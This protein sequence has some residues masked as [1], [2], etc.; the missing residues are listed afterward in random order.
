MAKEYILCVDDEP[1]VL[2][3]LKQ[4]IKANPF[5]AD[6]SVIILDSPQKAEGVVREILD[7]RGLIP[8]VISDQRMP[9]IT[10]DQLLISLH[11]VIPTARKILLTGYSDLD[12][13]VRLVN[14]NCLYRYISKPW[15]REDLTLT[16]RNAIGSWRQ[17][18]MI[19]TLSRRIESISLAMVTALENT[20][21]YFDEETGNHVQRISVLSEFIGKRAALDENFVHS[22]KLYS[23]LHD[24]GKVGIRKEVLL[25][26]GP[27]TSEEFEHIKEHV[28]IGWRIIDNEDIDPIA[29]NIV[30]YHHERWGG[31]GYPDS[32]EGERIPLEARIVSIADVFDALVNKRIYKDA[33]SI[34]DALEIME[35]GRGTYFDP[36]LL[37]VFVAGIRSIDFPKELYGA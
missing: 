8:L 16:L 28:I 24:I 11:Q 25:K 3:S 32:L 6:I 36:T 21:H 19:E 7:E 30:R 22:V 14:N 10:G 12:A 29:K 13:V 4:E 26:P 23:P 17:E 37:D 18:R 15:D 27:L 2:Q 1:I 5:F 9:G 35:N 33:M 34:H 31:K 20:N